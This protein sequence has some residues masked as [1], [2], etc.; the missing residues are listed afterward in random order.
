MTHEAE[1]EVMG[2]KQ[3]RIRLKIW[4]KGAREPI[5]H[6]VPTRK[7]KEHPD[8]VKACIEEHVERISARHADEVIPDEEEI[9]DS[10]TVTFEP[11]KEPGMQSLS[12]EEK[13]QLK[14]QEQG[15]S[16]GSGNN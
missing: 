6:G 15:G 1:Y 2:K 11:G 4:P 16:G 3:G 10:G 8:G 12:P 13:K 5:Q 14:Q 9:P 7:A